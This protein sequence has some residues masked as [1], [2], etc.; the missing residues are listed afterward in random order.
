VVCFWLVGFGV[1]CG[2]LDLLDPPRFG[3]GVKTEVR[4]CKTGVGGVIQMGV[5]DKSTQ[6]LGL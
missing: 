1:G 4:L 6:E 2:V 5:K 3:K